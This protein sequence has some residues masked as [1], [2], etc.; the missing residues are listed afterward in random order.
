M[1]LQRT[2][3][4]D[5]LHL[6]LTESPV[7]ALVGPRQ[8]GKTTLARMLAE[9]WRGLVHSFDLESPADLARLANPELAL[10]SLEGLVILDEVQRR[11]DL[12]PLLRV[13]ADRPGLPARF[14]VLGSASPALVESGSESLAGR[15]AFID[16]TGFSLAE[17][18]SQALAP[19]WWRGGFP[20]A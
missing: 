9:S 12:F 2:G 7:V 10:R 13:L 1:N 18:G 17:L 16:V 8:A 15:V 11:P 3:Y 14:L 4:L 6:R 5:T 19:L 20:R